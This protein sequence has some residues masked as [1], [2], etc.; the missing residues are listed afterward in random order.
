[1]YTGIKGAR[2]NGYP[3][4]VFF[5]TREDSHP[6]TVVLIGGGALTIFVSLAIARTLIF[7]SKIA[8]F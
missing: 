6:I 2:N 8:K 7:S 4:L 3:S 1:M 5:Y